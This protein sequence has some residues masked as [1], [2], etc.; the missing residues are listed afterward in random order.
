MIVYSSDYFGLL[1]LLTLNGSAAYRA[2]L[3]ALSSTIILL[4]YKFTWGEGELGSEK[5]LTDHPYVITIYVMAFSLV[6]NFRLNY[7]Y[8]RYWESAT[9]L[10]MMTSKWVDAATILASFHYQ[11]EIYRP[12][13]PRPFGKKQKK[14]GKNEEQQEENE[15]DARIENEG[16]ELIEQDVSLA[17]RR[18]TVSL[19]NAL[20][21]TSDSAPKPNDDRA[22]MKASTPKRSGKSGTPTA[23]NASTTTQNLQDKDTEMTTFFNRLFGL[24]G[25][26]VDGQA[27]P[28]GKSPSS[29][30]LPS[31]ESTAST[32]E[33]PVFHRRIPSVDLPRPGEATVKSF[34]PTTGRTWEK[35]AK[36]TRLTHMTRMHNHQPLLRDR[37]TGKDV[38]LEAWLYGGKPP[39]SP[40]KH[41]HHHK[42]SDNDAPRRASLPAQTKDVHDGSDSDI[43][44][45]IHPTGVN[46]DREYHPQSSSGISSKSSQSSRGTAK[47]RRSSK[48]MAS[49]NPSK[50]V[51]LRSRSS[52]NMRDLAHQESS[53]SN[54]LTD[55]ELTDL[56]EEID[57]SST[58]SSMSTE[59]GDLLPS[60]FLQ[61]AAHLFSLT[62]A[63]AMASLRADLEGC[64]SPLVEYVPGQPFPPVNPD[65]MKVKVW[66]HGTEEEQDEILEEN[67]SFIKGSNEN[68]DGESYSLG[69][70]MG[71]PNIVWSSAK[72]HK[73]WIRNNRFRNAVYFLL[74]LSRSPRQ[75]TLYNA[76]RP[77]SVMGGLSDKE[78]E[79]LQKARGPEAQMALC[80]LWLKEFVSREHLDGSTGMVAPPIVARVYQFISDGFVQYNQCRKTAYTQFPFVHSQLTTFFLFVSIF[81]FPYLFYTY[82]NST[83]VACL[84]NFATLACFDG[85][86]E[87][88]R[89][90]QDPFYQFPND[91]PLNNYQV[92]F[93][94][95]LISCLYGGFHPDAPGRNKE[96]REKQ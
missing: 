16:Q 70:S 62:S 15:H 68:R 41:S 76:S 64:A 35:S 50:W 27:S 13:R 42:S 21:D 63:V 20:W 56:E 38:D 52:D 47:P 87:V 60:L 61:E 81:I 84:L 72:N 58:T 10:F 31:Q 2:F 88:A 89:E 5:D 14:E 4:L 29:P 78:V 67:S 94:E 43:M 30:N 49:L 22:A 80:L 17:R 32:V 7:S 75:R 36:T 53:D 54:F 40:K 85:M 19:D 26:V 65:E 24:G 96:R 92:Q 1:T 91:L 79:F 23:P 39:S 11:S 12:Y 57:S 77:F 6:L 46:S 55:L 18:R 9:Q 74:G 82:V 25:G 71:L 48:L 66:L 90:L 51:G 95:A 8:Q 44:N 83:V 59:E 37:S 69:P 73:T 33:R 93:N 34:Q 3:P 28:N 45:A 86:H